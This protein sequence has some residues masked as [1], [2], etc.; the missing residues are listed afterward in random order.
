MEIKK[1]KLSSP[2]LSIAAFII[3]IAAAMY[4]E[5]II[6]PL[7]MAIFISIICAQ[8]VR[9]LKKKKVPDGL[10]VTI[11]VLLI[12]GFYVG[13]FELISTSL[14]L[15]IQDAPKYQESLQ[16]TRESFRQFL[17][18][19]GMGGAIIGEQGSI[20]PARIMEFTKQVVA[21]LR[22]MISEELTFILLTIFLVAEIK[23]I[24]LKMEVISKYSSTSMDYFKSIDHN[25]RHYLSIK[26]ITSMATGILVGISLALIGVDYPV[27]WGFLAFLLNYIPTIGS[28]IAAIPAVLFSILAL[29][30]PTTFLTIG[31]YVIINFSIGSVLEPKILGRG[32]GLSTF[33]VFFGLIFWGFTFGYVG[34]F[35]SVPIMM[36]I[37]IILE[38]NPKTKWVAAMLGTE[39]DAKEMLKPEDP[40]PPEPPGEGL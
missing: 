35:L 26:T 1:A 16:E 29:G 27:L 6:S 40:I 12:L 39:S 19:R 10:A 23:S 20:D 9:W 4:A 5:A 17:A 38:K 32:L 13:L 25:I 11:V 31:A 15:F 8:A 3:I 24:N 14:S 21:N 37:K 22:Q 30:F 2:L 7:L 18:D 28:F 33:V 36:V 34:M